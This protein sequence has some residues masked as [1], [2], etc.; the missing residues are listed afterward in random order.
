MMV[1][2]LKVSLIC[3]LQYCAGKPRSDTRELGITL[4]LRHGLPTILPVAFRN[5]IRVQNDR[6]IRIILSLLNS[7]KAIKDKG[8]IDLSTIRGD[9][10]DLSKVDPKIVSDFQNFCEKEFW[11]SF[12]QEYSLRDEVDDSMKMFVKS[13][14]NHPL[15]FL[16]SLYSKE[17]WKLVNPLGFGRLVTLFK[18]LGFSYIPSLLTTDILSPQVERGLAAIPPSTRPLILGKLATKEEA[19]GKIRV[20]AILDY[21]TQLVSL[22]FHKVLF[23]YLKDIKH[24]D[25]TFDQDGLV[26]RMAAKKF[27]EA[28]SFDLK[29]ATDNIPLWLYHQVLVPRLG[30]VATR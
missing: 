17:A 15:A 6:W 25:G 18:E 16:D 21:W 24:V 10:L 19:A 30:H 7:Y 2:T 20:F 3:V 5:R 9:P 12:P 14:P 8:L 26:K 29:A 11:S 27:A 28:F 1:K 4:G 13:G 22:P 23:R